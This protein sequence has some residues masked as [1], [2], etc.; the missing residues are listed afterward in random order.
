MNDPR[1]VLDTNVILAAKRSPTPSSPGYELLDRCRRGEWQ[2]LYSTDLLVEYA[3][4]LGGLGQT[5]EWVVEVIALLAALGEEVEI[6][7]F[8]LPKYPVDADDTAFLLCASN[9]QATHLAAYDR[10]LLDLKEVY[11]GQFEIGVPL[12]L[13]RVVRSRTGLPEI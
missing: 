12:Q 6:R 4:K 11:A 13:L 3:E 9:G 8:H 7:Y 1:G 10:H 5:R 2:L